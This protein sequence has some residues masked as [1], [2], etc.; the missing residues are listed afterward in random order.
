MQNK[1][2]LSGFQANRRVISELRREAAA[3]SWIEDSQ[4]EVSDTCVSGCV[5][6]IWTTSGPAMT[7]SGKVLTLLWLHCT[8]PHP[9][10]CADHNRW[11]QSAR[12]VWAVLH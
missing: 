10:L 9:L 4:L 5:H 8:T 1:E 2:Q 7:T 11:E 3:V 6:T 12:H